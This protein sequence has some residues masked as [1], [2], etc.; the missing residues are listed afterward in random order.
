MKRYKF[1]IIIE[2]GSDIFWE[3]LIEERRTGCEDL[4]DMIEECFAGT[5]LQESVITLK[6]FTDKE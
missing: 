4:M 1:E 5:G 3:S 2:E 6:E